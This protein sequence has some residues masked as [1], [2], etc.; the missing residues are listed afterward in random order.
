MGFEYDGE[1]YDYVYPHV[2]DKLVFDVGANIG[3]VTKKF[4]DAGAK[5]VAIEPQSIVTVWDNY[6]GVYAIENVCVS[7]EAGE[8][9]FYT[10]NMASTTATC[11]ADWKLLHPKAKWTK[12]VMQAVTL[13]ELIETYGKPTYIKVDVEGY[14][15]KV[16]G[17]LSQKIDFIS[18]EFTGGYWETFSESIKIVEKF[19]FKKM[20][21]F[22]KKK[23]KRKVDGRKKTIRSYKIV[24][25]FDNVSSVLKFFK[26]IPHPVQGDILIES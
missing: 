10:N 6:K 14:E 17:G 16:L 8:I 23:I 18:L 19:G 25:E 21:T 26:K 3:E 2:K 11:Y 1:A 22:I 24:D 9:V 20:T 5:V 15:H 12:N 4:I 13:D 7:D